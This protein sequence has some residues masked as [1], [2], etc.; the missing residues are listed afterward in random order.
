MA[1]TKTSATT[2]GSRQPKPKHLGVKA[3]SGTSVKAG[4]ILVRQ[5]GSTFY[6][7]LGVGM[8]KDFTL[9][10][11]TNGRVKFYGRDGKHFISV[12]ASS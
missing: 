3:Y 7:G 6:P 8:G 11:L 10:A 2:K 5:H 4:S 1:H 12:V 9:F